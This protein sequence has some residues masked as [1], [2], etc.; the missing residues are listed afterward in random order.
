[1]AGSVQRSH[2]RGGA[3]LHPGEILSTPLTF[4][5]VF[6]GDS[7]EPLSLYS[8]MLQK[9]GLSLAHPNASDYEANW[10][11]WGYEMDFTPKQMLGTI[12][13]LKELGLKWA[14]LDAGW[15]SRGATGSH[16]PTPFRATRCRRWSG[17]IT[18]PEFT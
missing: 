2:L 12:P 4:V 7:D 5:S 18:T 14:T 15:F 17:P 13:K 10:C 1:M 6:K 3:P 11:G 16:A 9:H 8:R